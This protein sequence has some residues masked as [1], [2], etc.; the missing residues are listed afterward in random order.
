MTHTTTRGNEIYLK[1]AEKM[2]PNINWYTWLN[3]IAEFCINKLRKLFAKNGYKYK[4]FD[5]WRVIG[6]KSLNHLNTKDAADE[7]DDLIYEYK[8][9]G[10]GR[11]KK[12]KRQLGG[13][14]P[15]FERLVPNESQ[16]N[17][18]IRKLPKSLKNNLID[19]VFQA[20]IELALE[21][22]ILEENVEVYIDYTDKY[23]YGDDTNSTNP[24]IIGVYNGPG[25]NKARKYL[26]IMVSSAKTKLFAQI[27]R[28]HV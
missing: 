24:D 25:T 13:K 1:P 21:L 28:A 15:R 20:Q 4:D 17:A 27:G 11:K 7:L 19:Y 2:V 8:Q 9:K 22:G 14:Y 16:V 23:Y 5:F 18:Y 6:Y 26:G 3:K 12:T 10:K